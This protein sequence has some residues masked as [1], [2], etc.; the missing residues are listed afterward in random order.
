M[1]M[2]SIWSDAIVL[3]LGGDSALH[4]TIRKDLLEDSFGLEDSQELIAY[5]DA[6]VSEMNQVEIDW[7]E[8][9]LQSGTAQYKQR[10]REL[11]PELSDRAVEVLGRAF[12]FWWR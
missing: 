7:T 1:E 3:Y 12:S 6:V 2:D 8:C 5:A 4:P 11:H 9:D 10:V